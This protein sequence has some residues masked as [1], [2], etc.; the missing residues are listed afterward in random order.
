MAKITIRVEAARR[1]SARRD[2]VAIVIV[3]VVS[4]FVCA[5]FNLSE[6]LLN[7]PVPSNDCS[8]MNFPRSC[9]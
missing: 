9:W 7:G 3:A 6:A 8:S 1:I 2:I 5:R 4:A